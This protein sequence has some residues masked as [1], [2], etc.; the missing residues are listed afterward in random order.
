MLWESLNEGE[1]D[2]CLK[3]LQKETDWIVWYRANPSK[4]ECVIYW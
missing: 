2:A 4:S 1:K 3:V